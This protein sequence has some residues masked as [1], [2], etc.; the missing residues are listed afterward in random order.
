MPFIEKCSLEAYTPPKGKFAAPY[1]GDLLHYD[2]TPQADCGSTR[3]MRTV[4]ACVRA[5]ILV[6]VKVNA[7]M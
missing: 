3:D 5:Y 6:C 7:Y 1:F 4:C 2:V